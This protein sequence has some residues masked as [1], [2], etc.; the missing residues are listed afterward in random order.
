MP[1]EGST[2]TN[3]ISSVATAVHGDA[4]RTLWLA[5]SFPSP[6]TSLIVQWYNELSSRFFFKVFG[7]VAWHRLRRPAARPS[8]SIAVS[9][10]Q[11]PRASP[12]ASADDARGRLIGLTTAE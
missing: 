7:H 4:S 2:C 9:F 1:L 10:A 6:C 8:V 3:M 11:P 12:W 5:W